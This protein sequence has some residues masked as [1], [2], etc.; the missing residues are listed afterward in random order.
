MGVVSG[1]LAGWVRV[2]GWLAVGG[3]LDE[4]GWLDSW[5]AVSAQLSAWL[6]G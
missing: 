3:W 4:N 1:R 6:S 2:A 5:L